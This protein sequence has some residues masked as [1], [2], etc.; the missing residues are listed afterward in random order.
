[1]VLNVHH[2][3]SGLSPSVKSIHSLDASSPNIGL[4]F[5]FS[6]TFDSLTPLSSRCTEYR[7][8]MCSV[9]DSLVKTLA[10][11]VRARDLAVPVVDSGSNTSVLYAK[12]GQRGSS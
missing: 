2:I 6:V 3:S 5:R 8:L 4:T 1:M 9:A 11:P 10:S 12:R 7:N